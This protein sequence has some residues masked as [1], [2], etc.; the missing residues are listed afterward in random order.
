MSKNIESI[1]KEIL[2]VLANKINDFYLAGGTALSLFYF[3]HRKSDDLDFFTQEFSVKRIIEITNEIN[4]I[5]NKN[6]ELINENLS[7]TYAKVMVYSLEYDKDKFLKID[8][9]QDFFSL[10]KSTNNINGINILS[11]EDI[12]LRKIYAVSGFNKEIDKIGRKKFFGGRQEAKD[13]FDIYFLSYS[14]MGLADFIDKYCDQVLKEGIIR[15]FRTFNRLEMKI[16]LSEIKT[17]KMIEFRDIDKHFAGEINKILSR[18]IE[19]S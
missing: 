10:I 15:W 19:L 8:F 12:Y 2:N 14:F 18:E 17:D 1:Q 9:I 6:I 11:Q 4:V 3:N 16:G 5:T 7:E 13:L